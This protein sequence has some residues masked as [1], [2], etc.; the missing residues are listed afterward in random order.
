MIRYKI[1]LGI[2]NLVRSYRVCSW[3]VIMET[4]FLAGF[5]HLE[6]LCGSQQRPRS[7]KE[8]KEKQQVE[9]CRRLTPLI[10]LVSS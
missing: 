1:E 3:S 2:G 7:L 9:S 10:L 4:Y 8:K 6:P 5:S